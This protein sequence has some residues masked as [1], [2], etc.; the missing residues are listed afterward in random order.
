MTT[1]DV[2]RVVADRYR[3][4]SL[5]HRGQGVET[6][7]AQDLQGAEPRD[8]VN[9]DRPRP[10]VLKLAAAGSLTEPSRRR[11]EHES[12]VL[13]RMDHP[14][15]VGLLDRGVDGDTAYLVT[16]WVPGRSLAAR[17][18]RRPPVG[19]R[20][21]AGRCTTW[22]RRCPTPTTTGSCTVT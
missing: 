14:N 5:L 3:L 21:L 20:R 22:W 16:P 10:V 8:A 11:L 17:L 1:V 4:T 6:Y 7:L 12:L 13:G 19:G 18:R 2:D 15:L 9:P